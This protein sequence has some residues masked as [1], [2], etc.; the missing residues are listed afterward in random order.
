MHIFPILQMTKL[1]YE[2]DKLPK[3]AQPVNGR[4]GLD[5]LASSSG[6]YVLNPGCSKCVSP[7]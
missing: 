6:A 5:N 4:A 2:K 3:D 7:T 1:S